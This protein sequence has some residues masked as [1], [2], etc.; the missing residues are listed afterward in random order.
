MMTI[1]AGAIIRYA[2]RV[3]L[4]EAMVKAIDQMFQMLYNC[5]CC[6]KRI[7]VEKVKNKRIDMYCS[8]NRMLM[9]YYADGPNGKRVIAANKKYCAK[10]DW[11]DA[12][13]NES[14]DNYVEA[15]MNENV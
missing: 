8:K 7:S 12:Q 4:D 13:R 9:H 1:T 3:M 10:S 15:V 2:V 11:C 5:M 14:Y 6:K